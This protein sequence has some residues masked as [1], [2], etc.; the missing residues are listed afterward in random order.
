MIVCR[1]TEDSH[2]HAS[3]TPQDHRSTCEACQRPVLVEQGLMEE[4]PKLCIYCAAEKH[5]GTVIFVE[6]QPDEY[7]RRSVSVS[8]E[9]VLAQDVGQWHKAGQWH[10]Q[11]WALSNIEGG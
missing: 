2:V 3:A 10:D 7:G 1:R 4:S 8:I 5:P 11:K 6:L 9:Q